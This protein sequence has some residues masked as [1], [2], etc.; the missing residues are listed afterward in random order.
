MRHL[1]HVDGLRAV[2]IIPVVAFHADI[3]LL[4]GGFIGVDVF[5]VISG[6]LIASLILAEL[7]AGRFSFLDFYKRR[8]LRILPAYIA[9][10]AAVALAAWAFMLP[11]EAR[12]VGRTIAAAS[13]FASNIYFWRETDYFNPDAKDDPL[14]HTWTLSVEEQ[15]YIFLPIGLWLIARY[16]GG[17]FTLILIG[18]SLLS[19][20]ASI[21]AIG[22]FDAANFYLLPTRAWEFGLGVLLAVAG[23][24]IGAARSLREAGAAI[25]LALVIAGV[26]LLDETSPFPGPA[27]L[28]PVL[29]ATL[30]IG[31]GEG[32]A[33]G[34]GL[35]SGA[36]VW[37]GKISY[38]VYLWHWPIIVFYKI[39][40]GAILD[41]V[42]TAIVVAASFLVGA[43][44]CAYIERPFRTPEMR[45][46]SSAGITGA[47]LALLAGVAASGAAIAVFAD[48]WRDYPPAALA[49]AEYIGFGDTDAGREEVGPAPCMVNANTV[50]RGIEYADDVCLPAGRDAP[51]WLLMGDS[52]AGHL[53]HAL[54]EGFPELEMQ[55]AGASGC[56]PV[57]DARGASWCRRL[58][59]R[60]LEE[61][62]P[63]AGLD[64][65]VLS[66]RW[67][68]EA[69]PD[70]RATAAKL[71]D[72]AGVVVILG[73]TP[74]YLE[75]APKLLARQVL[76]GGAPLSTFLDPGPRALDADMKAMEWGE[77][78]RYVSLFDLL[79][80][81]GGCP[82]TAPD[83]APF[84][85]DY[86]HYTPDG[87][88]AVAA[89]LAESGALASGG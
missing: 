78:V 87:A 57:L 56:L 34:R 23:G 6:F 19:F 15:F 33:V 89:R 80:G 59:G 22:R 16:F 35:S 72:E 25:G 43:L 47:S 85:F 64:G 40:F 17:R 26:F 82:E 24:R 81:E 12:D 48:R 62:I 14:L 32:T 1:P 74:E 63:Q 18:V 51:K 11:Q 5:F 67:T 52:H 77:G 70:L 50:S 36:A 68:E 45:A 13:L 44:S 27:A 31:C 58:M 60:M 73:P 76:F 2:A 42:D 9:V 20:I 84:Q 28:L 39:R 49:H 69:A 3:A 55:T 88:R 7:Q 71:A 54:R 41:P 37:I 86:G 38:S 30:L 21:L 10:I 61:H 4:S 79:C 65:V 53:M 29:G 75:D 83:G 46:R 8:A 66:A